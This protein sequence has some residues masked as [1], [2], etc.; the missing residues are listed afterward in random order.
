[1]LTAEEV[2]AVLRTSRKV[3]YEMIGRG[4][5]ELSD[6]RRARGMR[7]AGIFATKRPCTNLDHLKEPDS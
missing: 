6:S 2:T 3:I 1:M 4:A 5:R 7:A